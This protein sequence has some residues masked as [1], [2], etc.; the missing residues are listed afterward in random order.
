MLLQFQDLPLLVNRSSGQRC[1]YIT[2]TLI[3][4]P[5]ITELHSLLPT[6]TATTIDNQTFKNCR[7][8]YFLSRIT[9]TDILPLHNRHSGKQCNTGSVVIS[10]LLF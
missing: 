7:T 4:P 10:L 3:K 9:N 5:Y 1:V 6:P 8:I 2:G